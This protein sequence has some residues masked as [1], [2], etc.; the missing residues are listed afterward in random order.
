MLKIKLNNL[1]NWMK[2]K[3]EAFVEVK[4]YV[5]PICDSQLFSYSEA[6][7]QNFK[8]KNSECV[9]DDGKPVTLLKCTPAGAQSW[10]VFH[11]K[12]DKGRGT[13]FK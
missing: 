11:N 2:K 4:E 12:H 6:V 13:S 8:C 1:L 5:C 3:L 10:H 9:D 7:E